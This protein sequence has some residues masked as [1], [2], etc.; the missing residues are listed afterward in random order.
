M[1]ERDRSRFTSLEHKRPA[2]ESCRFS[3]PFAGWYGIFGLLS[4]R[5]R[6]VGGSLTW[7]AD[8]YRV[9]WLLLIEGLKC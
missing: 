9:N 4:R 6:I 8:A 2:T 1:A 5:S 3:G 7:S